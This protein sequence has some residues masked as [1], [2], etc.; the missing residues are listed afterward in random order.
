MEEQEVGRVV[1]YF[2]KIGVAGIEITGQLVVGDTIH[3]K[4][5]TSD[6]QQTVDSMQIEHAFIEEA[7]PGDSVGIKVKERCRAHDKIYKVVE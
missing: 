5:H 7:K 2:A 4:G 3:I 6:F 1:D